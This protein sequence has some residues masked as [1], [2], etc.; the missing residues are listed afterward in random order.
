M[1]YLNRNVAV[2][3]QLINPE[4]QQQFAKNC[5]NIGYKLF[6]PVVAYNKGSEMIWLKLFRW[7]WV[8]LMNHEIEVSKDGEIKT[9]KMSLDKITFKWN[10][11]SGNDVITE[12]QKY[13][14]SRNLIHLK[15][16]AYH[17][18]IDLLKE[19]QVALKN[20]KVHDYLQGKEWDY[21]ENKLKD[22]IECKLCL[23]TFKSKQELFGHL[24]KYPKHKKKMD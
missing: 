17:N 12:W 2:I 10:D 18:F 22:R 4:A 5:R 13:L 9:A 16:I 20:I 24:K 3:Y 14:K 23:K 8:E 1:G 6:A 11:I 21:A 15:C 19:Y 7:G